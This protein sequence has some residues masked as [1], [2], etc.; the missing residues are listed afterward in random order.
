MLSPEITYTPRITPALENLRALPG[1]LRDLRPLMTQA[2]VPAALEMLRR[3][4]DSKGAA[5]G[6]PWA[7]L[8]PSTLLDRIRKGTAAKGPLRDTDNL[9][10]ALF[11]SVS[12]SQAL[13]Q[14]AG[15][16]R[17]SLGLAANADPLE[18]LKALFHQHG[19]SRMP[20]RQVIPSPL[21]RSFRDVV[22]AMV[23]DWLATGRLRGAGGR[24]VAVGAG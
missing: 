3:H 22:R 18:R 10:L 17:L 19:T 7:P 5:F 11:A 20:A 24:F 15:G 21:P 6:H 4:W 8:A 9:F 2:I 1:R 23:L 14:V 16:I 13:Q 12:S